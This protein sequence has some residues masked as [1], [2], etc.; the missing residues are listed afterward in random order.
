MP[1]ESPVRI[2]IV[3]DDQI[4]LDSLR[5]FFDA[6]GIE[7]ITHSSAEAFLAA[8]SDDVDCVLADLKMPGM[9][10]IDLLQRIVAAG[11]PPVCMMTSFADNHTKTKAS[12]LG[13]AGFLEKP[14]RSS[15]LLDFIKRSC[16]RHT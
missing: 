6:V 7:A 2:A 1:T 15:E 4:L 13:A 11:G 9:S 16:P 14:I 12:S 10:G 3:D 5:D 8:H